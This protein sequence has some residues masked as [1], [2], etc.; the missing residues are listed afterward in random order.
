MQKP[1]RYYITEA[2]DRPVVR[3]VSVAVRQEPNG[4]QRVVET[5]VETNDTNQLDS[6]RARLRER[7]KSARQRDYS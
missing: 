3:T 6:R 1:V 4:D 2:E 5:Q 7:L